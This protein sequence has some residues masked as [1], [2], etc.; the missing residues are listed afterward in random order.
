MPGQEHA[1]PDRRQRLGALSEMAGFQVSTNG[2]FWV[3]TEVWKL[4]RLGRDLAH[5]VAVVSDLAD[6]ERSGCGY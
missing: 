3:S 6:L 4:D 1:V 2:R 5:L